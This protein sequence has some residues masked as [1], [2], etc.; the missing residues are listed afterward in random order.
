MCVSI[1]VENTSFRTVSVQGCSFIACYSVSLQ[2]E[3]FSLEEWCTESRSKRNLKACLSLRMRLISSL[4]LPCIWIWGLLFHLGGRKIWL[5][6]PKL[7]NQIRRRRGRIQ[8]THRK[9]VL[10]I[11]NAI[12]CNLVLWQT[13]PVSYLITFAGYFLW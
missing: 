6:T 10:F 12:S 1:C 13:M 11:F 3:V 2:L 7:L 4:G 8:P 9:W 5:F